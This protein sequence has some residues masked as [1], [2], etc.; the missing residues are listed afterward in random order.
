[1]RKKAFTGKIFSQVS[2]HVAFLALPLLRTVE[3]S[4]VGIFT[5]SKPLV[6]GSMIVR[7]M[8]SIFVPSLPLRVYGPMSYEVNT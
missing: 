1:M 8:K 7:H 3:I 5:I 2:V 6:A 4:T